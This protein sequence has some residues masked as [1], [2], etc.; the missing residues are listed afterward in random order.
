MQKYHKQMQEFLLAN[1]WMSE[2]QDQL[3]YLIF[4]ECSS[5]TERDLVFH[6][7]RSGKFMSQQAYNSAIGELVREAEAMVNRYSQDIIVVATSIDSDPD[8]SHELI[9]AIKIGLGRSCL[10]QRIKPINSLN[11]LKDAIKKSGI[12]KCLWID[13]FIGTGTSIIGRHKEIMTR[14]AQ[15]K[16]TDVDVK[17]KVILSTE[18]GLAKVKAAGINVESLHSIRKAIADS[19]GP[20]AME[21]KVL[22]GMCSQFATEYG[23]EQLSVLGW[24]DSEAVYGRERGN[25]PNNVLPILWWGL[26]KNGNPRPF[27]LSRFIG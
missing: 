18:E 23:N 20:S 1:P 9:Y 25:V 10:Q 27:V 14:F 15:A 4:E 7:L 13:E 6:F 26:Y 21:Y 22:D 19:F 12:K 8:S 5:N 16:I 17:V 24:G 11:S 3:S 2:F